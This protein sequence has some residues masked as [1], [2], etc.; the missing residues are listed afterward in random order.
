VDGN[1]CYSELVGMTGSRQSLSLTKMDANGATCWGLGTV[2]HELLHVVGLWHEQMRYDRDDYLDIHS[3]NYG[4]AEFQFSK[5]SS[6]VTSTYNIP[7]NYRSIMHYSAWAFSTNGKPTMT[8]KPGHGITAEEVGRGDIW[9]Y[10]GDWEKVRRMYNCKGTYAPEPCA[11]NYHS[12]DVYK[13]QC[14]TLEWMKPS[15]PVTCGVCPQGVP[16]VKPPAE[17][18]EDKITYCYQYADECGKTEWLKKSC[19][20]TCKFCSDNCK[21]DLSYCATYVD[22]CGKENWT[23]TSCRKTCGFC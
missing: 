23:K 4:G 7:Y 14:N 12:C 1:G 20:K 21:D 11:D 2:M 19:S 3:E 6:N 18:C 9:E 10:E 15:C 22:Q 17:P 8:P 5:V 16:T 13:N